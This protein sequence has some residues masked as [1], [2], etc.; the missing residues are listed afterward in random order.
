MKL[1]KTS[2]NSG[3]PNRATR[4][5]PRLMSQW[6]AKNALAI[7]LRWAEK[8]S[9]IRIAERPADRIIPHRELIL[10]RANKMSFAYFIPVGPETL[11]VSVPEIGVDIQLKV[12]AFFVENWDANQTFGAG[13][14]RVRSGNLSQYRFFTWLATHMGD[15]LPWLRVLMAKY[16]KAERNLAGVV[17][18]YDLLSHLSIITSN[19][20][21]CDLCQGPVDKHPHH[22]ECR[23]CGA[24][25]DL[26]T[27]IMSDMSYPGEG[28]TVNN[29]KKLHPLE[30]PVLDTK[31]TGDYKCRACGMISPGH[32]LYRDPMKTAAV[33]TCA[34]LFCGGTCDPVSVGAW[35]EKDGWPP[36][37][38]IKPRAV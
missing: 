38:N 17:D 16:S 4:R 10:T 29:P 33:F 21:S 22:F 3:L 35:T 31:P 7:Q 36:R 14:Y 5:S 34:D 24:M 25:G 37:L 1:Q 11:Y 26:N 19:A 18:F 23:D 2:T 6:R 27:G 12:P 8:L 32:T 20:K 9:G 30:A 28:R 13:G 15:K